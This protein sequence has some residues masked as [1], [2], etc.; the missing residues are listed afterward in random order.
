M[1]QEGG[2]MCVLYQS[3]AKRKEK[4]TKQTK[5]PSKKRRTSKRKSMQN[6]A[7]VRAKT[8]LQNERK[9]HTKNNDTRTNFRRSH[10]NGRNDMKREETARKHRKMARHGEKQHD[11]GET[12]RHHSQLQRSTLFVATES[13]IAVKEDIR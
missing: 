2:E 9:Q 10:N 7:F 11:T 8:H 6:I 3:N 5:A 13:Q 12:A 4:A 1:V